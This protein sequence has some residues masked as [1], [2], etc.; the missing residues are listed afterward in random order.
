MTNEK[1][2]LFRKEHGLTQEQLA[3]ALRKINGLKYTRAVISKMERGKMNIS[4]RTELSLIGIGE[5]E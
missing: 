2:K 5:K 4:Q 3:N 1:L